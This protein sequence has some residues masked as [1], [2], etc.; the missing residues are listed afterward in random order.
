MNSNGSFFIRKIAFLAITLAVCALLLIV[1]KKILLPIFIAAALAYIIY[2]MV[3][4]LEKKGLPSH[5]GSIAVILA[6][7]ILSGLLTYLILRPMVSELAS[8]F[9]RVPVYEK[10]LSLW[11]EANSP[12][13]LISLPIGPEHSTLEEKKQII[14]ARVEKAIEGNVDTIINYIA[15]AGTILGKGLSGFFSASLRLLILPVLTFYLLVAKKKI[16]ES[17][18]ELIPIYIKQ[19]VLDISGRIDTIL[20]AYIK[21][22]IIVSTILSL[23][24]GIVLWIGGSPLI[25]PLAILTGFGNIIPFFGFAAGII[26]SGLLALFEH[27]IGIGFWF[28][29]SVFLIGQMIESYFLTPRIVGRRVNLHPVVI[30][31]GLMVGSELFGFFGILLTIPGLAILH[32]IWQ[33]LKNVYKDSDLYTGTKRVTG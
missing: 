25:I 4:F 5:V 27:G 33:E 17:F 30:L 7:T 21:G 19:R 6:A 10:K 28:I 22:Q 15:K 23:Y 14:I 16:F 26:L 29:I 12:I 24:Y 3:A 1:L 31:I 18:K 20:R 2:P 32:V 9:S 11:W 8:F 13:W